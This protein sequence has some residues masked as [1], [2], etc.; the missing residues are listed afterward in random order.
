M[1]HIAII[2]PCYNEQKRLRK[3][4]FIEF[5]NSNPSIHLIFVNDGSTDNTL[6]VIKEMVSFAKNIA[7]VNLIKNCGKGEAVRQGILYALKNANLSYIGFLDA[8]LSTSLGEYFE[9]C[10]YCY[11][12]N[13]DF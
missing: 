10:T 9:L 4:T 13:A 5:A 6:Q 12:K 7:L 8:D 1:P 3:S 11:E 2:I